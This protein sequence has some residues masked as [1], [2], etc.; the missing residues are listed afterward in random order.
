MFLDSARSAIY[1][2]A[3][4]FSEH[5][6]LM[7]AYTCPTVWSALEQAGVR[8]DFI[9]IDESLDFDLEDLHNVLE[10][11]GGANI[12]LIPTSLF[13]SS[14]RDYKVLFKDFLI[15]EDRAQGIQSNNT[16]A[17]FQVFSFGKGKMFS[18]FGGGGI[19]CRQEIEGLRELPQK[20]DFMQSYLLSLAQKAISRVWGIIEKTP[21][22]PEKSTHLTVDAIQPEKLGKR[23]ARWILNTVYNADF[24][25]R[26]MLSNYYLNSIKREYLFDLKG[27]TPY[28]RIPIKK[29][30]RSSGVSKMRDYHETYERACQKRGRVLE[31]AKKLVQGCFLPTHDLV[32]MQYAEEIVKSI[33]E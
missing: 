19:L 15:I 28:L 21:F 8:Y 32:S 20:D 3:K 25:H 29:E 31:G 14:I 24:A 22:D 12:A 30:F 18:G 27:D 1:L 4:Q 2:I 26:V 23:K 17:D 33:N 7:P 10:K 9:D 11:Y 5:T 16:N 6:F 13:G